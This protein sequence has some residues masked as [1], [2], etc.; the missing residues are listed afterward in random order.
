MFVWNWNLF[1]HLRNKRQC[2]SYLTKFSVFNQTFLQNLLEYSIN[3]QW[4]Y[5]GLYS[6]SR[7]ITIRQR[8]GYEADIS[9]TEFT[10]WPERNSSRLVGLEDDLLQFYQRSL[11]SSLTTHSCVFA[12]QKQNRSSRSLF[13]PS[14]CNW[15]TDPRFETVVQDIVAVFPLC[16]Q[17]KLRFNPNN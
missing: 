13:R 11:F 16:T 15:W 2:S 5:N 12:A 17:E 7:F 1:A 4:I 3:A 14:T 8:I 6:D 10:S 9:K